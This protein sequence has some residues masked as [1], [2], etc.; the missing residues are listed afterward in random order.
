M[1]DFKV[2]VCRI[3]VEKHPDPEVER[4]EVAR[5]GDFMTVVGKGNHQ[6]G[7]LVAYIPEAAIV[8]DPI[9][10][11]IGVLG[12]LSGTNKNRVKPIRLRGV[13]SEGLVLK[14]REGWVEGQDVTEELGIS[15][16]EPPI[17]EAMRSKF[18][19]RQS[20]QGFQFNFDLENIK[21]HNRAFEDGEEVVFTEKLHGTCSIVGWHE[22]APNDVADMFPAKFMGAGVFQIGTKNLSKIGVYFG[23]RPE[24]DNLY[25]KNFQNLQPHFEQMVAVIRERTGSKHIFLL[26]EIFG[27]GVQDLTYGCSAGTVTYRMFAVAYYDPNEIKKRV[28]L[29][30]DELDELLTHQSAVKRVPVVYRGPFSK[31]V[32]LQ[33]TSGKDYSGSHIREGVVV[34]PVVERNYGQ[35]GRLILKS[36]SPEYLFRKGNTTEF[37]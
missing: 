36:V 26:G 31:E 27:A 6:T 28:W 19:G 30:S 25:V 24:N 13:I 1:S 32:L 15:K 9:A 18:G 35:H 7:D 34:Q 37:T 14:A 8:P 10:E 12:K 4:L 2:E 22:K 5:V 23:D 11:E 16:Y 29:S 33:H 21:K 20:G 3:V 17:P